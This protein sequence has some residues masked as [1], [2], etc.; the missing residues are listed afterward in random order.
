MTNTHVV[1][2]ADE[3][4]VTLED[5]ETGLQEAKEKRQFGSSCKNFQRHASNQRI[6][7]QRG[8]RASPHAEGKGRTDDPIRVGA[9]T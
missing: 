2:G 7:Q 3:V 4:S 9:K 5:F 6:V 8:V 1:R